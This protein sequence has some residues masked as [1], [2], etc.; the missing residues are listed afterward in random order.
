MS[1]LRTGVVLSPPVRNGDIFYYAFQG[2]MVAR[3][4]LNPYV[5]PP[6]NVVDDEWFPFVSPIWRNLTT[7]YGP[8]WLLIS[9]GIDRGFDR[10]GAIPDFVSTILAYRVL[11]AIFTVANVVLLWVI[12]GTLAP[13]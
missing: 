9:A 13:A 7:G 3:A 12:L 10:G 2:R 6:R 11:F 4:G 1:P 8:A 5:V